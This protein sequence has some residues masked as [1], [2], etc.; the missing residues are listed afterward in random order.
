MGECSLGGGPV[1]FLVQVCD[2][3]WG[4]GCKQRGRLIVG[5]CSLGGGPVAFLAQV[6]DVE[7]GAGCEQRGYVHPPPF[8]APGRR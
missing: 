2:V 7:W 5:E 3:E 4:A 1:A 8:P 6:C